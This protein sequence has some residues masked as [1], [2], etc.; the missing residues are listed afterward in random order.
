MIPRLRQWLM[1]SSALDTSAPDTSAVR[2]RVLMVCTGNICRSPTAEGVLRVKLQRAGVGAQVVVDSAG[3]QGYHTAEPPDPRA[4]R[5]AAQRGYDIAGIRARPL[6]PEDFARFDWLLAMDQGHLDWMAKRA[7]PNASG[8][9]G[10]LM[11]MARRHPGVRDVPDPYY[12]GPAG[13]DHVLDLVEDACE[14][15]VERLRVGQ[16][17]GVPGR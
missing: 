7:P 13:F 12:G 9:L 8:R 11:P 16:E 3:T 2:T 14:G 1:G 15:L 4:I 5:A 10:L 17:P 6:R